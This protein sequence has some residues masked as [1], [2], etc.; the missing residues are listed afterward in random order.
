MKTLTQAIKIV[1]VLA[2]RH[3]GS[4]QFFDES[5]ML[6]ALIRRGFSEQTAAEAIIRVSAAP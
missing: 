4:K 2:S 5:K 3:Y 1:K 6:S